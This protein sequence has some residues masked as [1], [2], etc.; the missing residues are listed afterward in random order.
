MATTHFHVSA[1]PPCSS[2]VAA[3][4]NSH[5]C[6]RNGLRDYEP[7]HAHLSLLRRVSG[8]PRA[9]ECPM[10]GVSGVIYLEVLRRGHAVGEGE[11]ERVQ[12]GLPP[13]FPIVPDPCPW[14]PLTASDQ[15]QGLQGDL[16]G[17]E[18]PRRSRARQYRE[19]RDSIA[20]V[21]NSTWRISTS[22]ARRGRE[23]L[24]GGSPQFRDGGMGLAP[25]LPAP[26]RRPCRSRR[27]A[28]C[29]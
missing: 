8:N 17:R 28:R 21:E 22:Y 19:C 26:Q 5:A 7:N 4:T 2:G 29:R 1:S 13:L 14:G 11:G 10:S 3:L 18:C 16:L 9:R 25:L 20:L 24:P 27:S 23:L 15:I 12:G 6:S